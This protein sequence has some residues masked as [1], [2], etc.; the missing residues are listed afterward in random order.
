VNRSRAL[1]V[2][3]I[4]SVFALRVSAATFV[5]PPDRTM[6]E[7]A[8]AI[9]VGSALASHAEE[10]EDGGIRTIT[11]MSV[12]SV[13]KGAI[14]T[15]TI[16]VEEPGGDL[17]ERSQ[18]IA[19]VPRFE[20]GGE[21]LVFLSQAD[22]R[23]HVLDLVCGKFTFG[24]DDAGRKI[25]YR[26]A[27][28]IIGWDPDGTPHFERNRDSVFFVDFI[29]DV[30]A[31]RAVEDEYYTD[32]RPVVDPL[33]PSK[34]PNPP[35]PLKGLSRLAPAP[36]ATYSATSYTMI[37]SGSLGSRWNV[38]P[39]PV[40]FFSVG[41]EPG[42][43]GS[44]TTAI[45]TAMASWNNDPNSNV[46]YV[47]GGADTTHTKG[48]SSADGVN[49]VMFE[50]DLSAYGV[51]PFSC[52]GSSFSGTLGLGGVTNASGTHNGPN[53]EAFAT[54]SEGDVEMNKGLA[55]CTLLFNN[56]DFNTAVAHELGHTLGFRHSDQTRADSPSIACSSD[57]TLECSSSAVMKSF[58]PNGINAALQP[59]DQHAVAAVYPGS[60]TA[61]PAPPTGVNA[62]AQSSTSVLVTWTAS[63]GATS[64]EVY[65]RAPGGSFTLI[66][67]STTA[68][69]TD[70]S[71]APNTTYLYRVRAVNAGG[72]S[73]DSG[74]DL[75][76]TVI[77][78]D[79]PLV[80]R[81]TVIKAVHLAELRTA[82]NAVRAQAGL[83]AASF[84]DAA[85]RGVIVKAV[86]ITELR[87]ALDAALGVLGF[88][89]GG[90][91][92]TIT[93]RSTIIKAVHFQELRN[94]VK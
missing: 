76:T 56:G 34:T 72:S 3:S 4:L 55:N 48:L 21:Y 26:D 63:S 60:S 81:S 44:G 91:T 74:Y 10:T 9:V 88:P 52:S 23:W 82:V 53:G 71:V 39:S 51:G 50:R 36:T 62:R 42:A 15:S 58:I 80:A 6:I 69:Y 29:K 1:V 49:T 65:R 70:N 8:L 40:T 61:T 19:G 84:T 38:F 87:T 45:T 41:T 12:R 77:F 17:G 86:H 73:A 64:Y 59:W 67:T 30:V 89:T 90:Y 33:P 68:S 46:N 24:S 66:G 5:V 31:G 14:L 47:Y 37:V 22:R 54:T 85:S 25:L 35:L 28:E 2:G 78:T 83:A 79:D 43:P 27:R 13:L 11:V 20:D 57:A 7:H 75:A 92:D 93:A 16:D 94:R 32:S 18:R